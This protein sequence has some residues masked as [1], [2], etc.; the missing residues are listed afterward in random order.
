[1]K[2]TM[3]DLIKRQDPLVGMFNANRFD[4]MIN[5]LYQMMDSFWEDKDLT[6]DAFKML[7]PKNSFPKINVSETDLAYEVEIAVSGFDRNNLELEF[8][9]SCLLIKATKTEESEDDNKRWLTRE[10]SNKSFRRTIH[11][12]SKIVTNEIKSKYNES[13]GTVICTLPKKIQEGPEIVKINID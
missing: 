2:S 7:Q 12:P 8:K 6:A 3:K 11:F 9:D 1:M 5:S 10:I 4:T 13:K